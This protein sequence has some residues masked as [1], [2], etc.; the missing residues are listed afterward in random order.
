MKAGLHQF[1][2]LKNNQRIAYQTDFLRKNIT[3]LAEKKEKLPFITISREY[4]CLGFS[5][6]DNLAEELNKMGS[7]D[8]PWAV[9]DKEILDKVKDDFNIDKKD[10]EELTKKVRSENLE[11]FITIFGQTKSQLSIYKKLFKTIERLAFQ[12]KVIL[13][14]RGSAI[15][16]KN[17]PKGLHVRIQA[18]ED[19]KIERIMEW[20]N[21][22]KADAKNILKKHSKEREGYVKKFLK[23]DLN[24][25]SHYDLIINNSRMAK[26]QII[27]IIIELLKNKGYI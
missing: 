26:E 10:L 8:M 19:W 17:I 18:P 21:C 22:G 16:T 15:I 25:I 14:G 6:G 2:D 11:L 7:T 23:A 13:I 27:S 24:D 5:I 3:F 1:V 4:G 20:E 9:Y 12:G